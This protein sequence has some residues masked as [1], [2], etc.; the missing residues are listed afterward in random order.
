[1]FLAA[2]FSFSCNECIRF[3]PFQRNDWVLDPVPVLTPAHT[4]ASALFINR[5]MEL[6]RDRTSGFFAQS[7]SWWICLNA[8][9]KFLATECSSF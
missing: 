8:C 7:S 3:L 2:A 6:F 4:A 1:M 5:H 9:A